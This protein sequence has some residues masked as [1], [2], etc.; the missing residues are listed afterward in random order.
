M[1]ALARWHG[2]PAR[3][4]ECARE[5]GATAPREA[6]PS[7]RRTPS[8]HRRLTMPAGAWPIIYNCMSEDGTGA[9]PWGDALDDWEAA[10]HGAQ[11]SPSPLHGGET[12]D[13]EL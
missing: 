10:Q 2:G 1:A 12:R 5:R 11:S 4:E 7:A 13:G 9:H 3:R 8:G 6:V